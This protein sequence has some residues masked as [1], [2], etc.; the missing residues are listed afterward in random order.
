MTA[1]RAAQFLI[2]ELPA[3]FHKAG[4][5]EKITAIGNR[6]ALQVNSVPSLQAFLSDFS[7]ISTGKQDG[8]VK[9]QLDFYKLPKEIIPEM[10]KLLSLDQFTKH[11]IVKYVK[12]GQARTGVEIEISPKDIPGDPYDYSY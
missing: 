2:E 7:V 6:I 11:R 10:A 12:N 1:A 4:A 9:V 8:S 3:L 5:D